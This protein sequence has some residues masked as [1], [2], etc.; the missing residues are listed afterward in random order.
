M[1]SLGAR[2]I[3]GHSDEGLLFLHEVRKRSGERRLVRVGVW[4]FPSKNK[5]GF[6]ISMRT[7]VY[8]VASF[9]Q[10]PSQLGGWTKYPGDDEPFGSAK[11]IRIFAGFV[12]EKDP[13]KF[14]IPV[15]VDS[16]QGVFTGQLT[17]DDRIDS[18]YSFPPPP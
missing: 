10:R 4:C 17:D 16:W 6:I 7:A 8:T 9:G 15:E 3:E 18:G 2:E 1:R 13:S 12:E 5:S 11:E 14:R